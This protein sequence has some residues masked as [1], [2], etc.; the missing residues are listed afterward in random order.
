MSDYEG[1]GFVEEAAPCTYAA[2]SAQ[3]EIDAAMNEAITKMTVDGGI[4]SIAIEQ[5][6]EFP[7]VDTESLP[8]DRAIFPARPRVW[9]VRGNRE[10]SL[11]NVPDFRLLGR[12][13]HDF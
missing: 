7:Q 9:L 6:F 8:W 12:V 1:G 3:I 10:C 13:T 4:I 2:L 5:L 11:A